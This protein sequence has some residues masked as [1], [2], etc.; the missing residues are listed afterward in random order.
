MKLASILLS[1]VLVVSIAGCMPFR[2][3]PNKQK[4]QRI[5]GQAGRI[6]PAVSMNI[7]A[8]YDPRLD[9][10]IAG[11]KLLTVVVKNMSLRNVVMDAKKDR[12]VIVGEKGHRYRAV[13]TLR[14]SDPVQWRELPE[15]MQTLI[16]YPE[17]IPINYGVT[18]DLLL[19][20]KAKLD[21]F[22]EIRYY[23][24]A[25]GQDFVLEKEY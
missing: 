22:K 15:K 5:E 13:N 11:Y 6:L 9:D 21:Y 18:F 20:K 23:N 12:W 2:S 16:D 1:G 10:V 17:I 19:P 3:N 7:D 14:Y 4:R 24:A 25:W 8:N